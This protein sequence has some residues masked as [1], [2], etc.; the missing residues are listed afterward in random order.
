MHGSA[1][2]DDAT[3]TRFDLSY[4]NTLQSVWNAE[5][6]QRNIFVGQYKGRE[7]GRFSS[8]RENSSVFI[9]IIQG[10]FEVQNRLLEA[11]DALS[12]RGVQKIEF[13]ALSNDAVILVLEL[14]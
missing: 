14:G 4:K 10:A 2:K 7:E 6:G 9:F 11:R 8:S 3:L 12:I 1:Q 5:D 13:E